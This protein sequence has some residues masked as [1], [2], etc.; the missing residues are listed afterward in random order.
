MICRFEAQVK[1]IP[2]MSEVFTEQ[3][4]TFLDDSLL[5]L[6]VHATNILHQFKG[7]NHLLDGIV[8][9][10]HFAKIRRDTMLVKRFECLQAWHNQ[11]S[12]GVICGPNVL[13]RII[14]L[15]TPVHFGAS[16][17]LPFHIELL[18]RCNKTIARI[19]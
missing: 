8:L 14:M 9:L 16:V 5:F 13:Y 18:L 2:Q 1:L 10:A 15:I 12:D 3:I 7:I 19:V 6:S 11:L 17:F 4:K